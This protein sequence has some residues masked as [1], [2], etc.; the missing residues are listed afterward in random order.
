MRELQQSKSRGY[1]SHKAEQ[2]GFFSHCD[3]MVA[4]Y[5]AALQTY[6]LIFLNRCES[7]YVWIYG[8]WTSILVIN[9][10][11]QNMKIHTRWHETAQFWATLDIVT[12]KMGPKHKS[13]FAVLY[14]CCRLFSFLISLLNQGRLHLTSSTCC[15]AS[16]S[17]CTTSCCTSA[18]SESSTPSAT[19]ASCDASST[20]PHSK[21][22][23]TPWSV[24]MSRVADRKSE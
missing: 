24:R 2:W 13:S 9:K 12:V 4:V 3:L 14:E 1:H 21:S 5:W 22:R 17:C 15:G 6:C 16:C 20:P 10:T 18:T 23:T 11:L 8:G 7:I 19:D